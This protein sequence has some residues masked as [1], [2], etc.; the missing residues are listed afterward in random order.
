MIVSFIINCFVLHQTVPIL[1]S[2]LAVQWKVEFP[3]A[4]IG[5]VAVCALRLCLSNLDVGRW[6]GW[7]IL[8]GIITVTLQWPRHWP[9]AISGH[10]WQLDQVS[11]VTIR[12]CQRPLPVEPQEGVICL[13]GPGDLP[14]LEMWPN[15]VMLRR[16]RDINSDPGPWV[17]RALEQTL[18]M[19]GAGDNKTL[20][21]LSRSGA[22]FVQGEIWDQI[23]TSG[24]Q[25]G[26]LLGESAG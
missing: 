11:C 25:W 13:L 21:P 26:S 3:V 23:G 18:V 9:R 2:Q 6:L 7:A 12:P 4:G 15:N 16:R 20:G 8:G 10:R 22:S 1:A 24:G 14:P 5:P 17:H 19:W